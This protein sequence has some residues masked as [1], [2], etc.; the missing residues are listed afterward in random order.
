MAAITYI[1]VYLN[2]FCTLLDGTTIVMVIVHT[3]SVAI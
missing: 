3:T 2:F 1:L